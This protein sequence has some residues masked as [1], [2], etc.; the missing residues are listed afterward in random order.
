M[1]IGCTW[2]EHIKSFAK[3]HWYSAVEIIDKSVPSTAHHSRLLNITLLLANDLLRRRERKELLPLPSTILDAPVILVALIAH[4]CESQ[5]TSIAAV[6]S[7][8]GV[9]T[10]VFERTADIA[11]FGNAAAGV[12][13]SDWPYFVLAGTTLICYTADVPDF[14]LV[15][16]N[17]G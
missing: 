7:A 8:Q 15:V 3:R 5:H 6:D 2:A 4:V 1:K 9:D 16:P 13:R 10:L 12:H 17:C 14:E 11:A